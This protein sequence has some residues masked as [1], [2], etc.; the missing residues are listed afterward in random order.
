MAA[1]LSGALKRVG[2]RIGR[3]ILKLVS[4]PENRTTCLTCAMLSAS[5]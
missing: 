1:T 3:P 4:V 2:E 5:T